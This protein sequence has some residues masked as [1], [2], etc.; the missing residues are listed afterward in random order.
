MQPDAYISMT[1]A[2][3]SLGQ[4]YFMCAGIKPSLHPFM[5]V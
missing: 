2:F 3:I 5:P 4:N 1:D